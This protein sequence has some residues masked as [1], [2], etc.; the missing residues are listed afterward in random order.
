MSFGQERST[1]SDALRSSRV[2]EVDLLPPRYRPRQAAIEKRQAERRS[3]WNDRFY[4][5]KIPEYDPLRD[6]S[7]AAYRAMLRRKRER[8]T[9]GKASFKVS[10]YAE[11]FFH[12]R[13]KPNFLLAEA[14]QLA[15]DAAPVQCVI[16]AV[17][18]RE[19]T[20]QKLDQI[21]KV[22]SEQPSALDS[23]SLRSELVM[24]LLALR[25]A[26]IR[27]VEAVVKW[28]ESL[29]PRAD[30]PSSGSTVEG[31]NTGL[32]PL[33]TDANSNV[34]YLIKMK[35]D[36]LWLADASFHR[37]FAFSSRS[38][39]FLVSPSVAPTTNRAR[40]PEPSS[41]RVGAA[42]R[43]APGRTV[44]LPLHKNQIARIQECEMALLQEAVLDLAQEQA[45]VSTEAVTMDASRDVPP[46]SNSEWDDRRTV[47]MKMPLLNSSGES[48]ARRV[49]V[50]ETSDLS[51]SG[52]DEQI[53]ASSE[54][55]T[56]HAEVTYSPARC[57][58]DVMRA[59]FENYVT[60]EAHPVSISS[61]RGTWEL[62]EAAV[63]GRGRTTTRGGPSQAS[64][65]WVLG[66][67]GKRIGLVVYHLKTHLAP[68]IHIVHISVKDLSFMDMVVTSLRGHIFGR[69]P[70]VT[71]I[72]ATLWYM[73]NPMAEEGS[74]E[75]YSLD[76][77]IEAS[78]QRAHFRWYQL[79][80]EADGRRGQVM[81]SRRNTEEL[82]DPVG[83]AD[84]D[85]T[86][87]NDGTLQLQTCTLSPMTVGNIT[88][89]HD[90]VCG[91]VNPIA[92]AGALV[93]AGI[94]PDDLP[95]D[96][97]SKALSAF[98]QSIEDVAMA[99]SAPVSAVFGITVSVS[100]QVPYLVCDEKLL[101]EEG[102]GYLL[103]VQFIARSDKG[104]PSTI[105]FIPTSD[106]E[107]LLAIM[108]NAGD[109]S[110]GDILHVAA[111]AL[112]GASRLDSPAYTHIVVPHFLEEKMST[113]NALTGRK[114]ASSRI[115][116]TAMSI[117]I[118]PSTPD[119]ESPTAA[120]R[121][122]KISG[123]V[124]FT[125]LS[126]IAACSKDRSLGF[127]RESVEPSKVA[128][129]CSEEPFIVAVCH[130]SLDDLDIP[131]HSSLV[132]PERL[133]AS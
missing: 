67:D 73:E 99:S 81:N 76:K 69:Y 46:A 86:V 71:T 52:D 18:R 39:P 131:L 75:R 74:K 44:H 132:C 16:K 105:F 133:Q 121:R 87:A 12:S 89:D 42:P 49:D 32:P 78:F 90:S 38:D 17:L 97:W 128:R 14:D 93:N 118:P 77:E 19:S 126:M 85:V 7:C 123:S 37:L 125:R 8:T 119:G 33:W 108:P 103:P 9:K 95:T 4:L 5:G 21:D 84:G 50:R 31:T 57:S 98:V 115:G 35:T 104:S 127:L 61:T 122:C 88:S 25:E 68:Q 59:E 15:R 40:V 34:N 24:N 60:T 2:S 83:L 27:C 120:D 96:I 66:E 130:A 55:V 3:G 79:T 45:L 58:N 109:T 13:T 82:G 1:R 92:L 102:Q 62:V 30:A 112:S 41:E 80:Q 107:V 100:V 22:V 10:H 53:H 20:I 23:A 94:V 28:R 56:T 63:Y 29:I 106:E 48:S 70:E 113:S 116:A 72:R 51:K 101:A 36:T 11:A 91:A 124:E 64:W 65:W 26:S 111:E 114:A 6:S 117:E 129:I 47:M 110:Q 43:R 54:G